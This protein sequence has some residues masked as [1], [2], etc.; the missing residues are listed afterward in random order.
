MGI[1]RAALVSVI[2]DVLAR[3]QVPV[4]LLRPGGRRV[5]KSSTLLV[6]VDGSPLRALTLGIAVQLAKT[7]GAQIQLVQVSQPASTWVYA[8]DAYGGTS[9][10]DTCSAAQ[11]TPSCGPP[12]ARCCCSTA[13][14][15]GPGGKRIRARAQGGDSAQCRC[16]CHYCLTNRPSG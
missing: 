13:R 1:N 12:N 4:L 8:G 9:Y 7:T 3:S 11:R 15:R 16:Y 10:Y 6:P 2:Q 5:T 14:T